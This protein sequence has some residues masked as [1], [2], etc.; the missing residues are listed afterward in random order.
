MV[1]RILSWMRG[2]TMTIEGGPDPGPPGVVRHG[3]VALTFSE[4]RG[5]FRLAD[6]TVLEGPGALYRGTGLEIIL[7]DVG[8]PIARRTSRRNRKRV[9]AVTV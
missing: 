9:S 5:F 3:F 7:F 1:N 2:L 6:D 4:H 8:C